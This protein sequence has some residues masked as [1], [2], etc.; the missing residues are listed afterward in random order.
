MMQRALLRSPVH[1]ATVLSIGVAVG[2]AST[3][4]GVGY[5]VFVKP[6][7]FEAPERVVVIAGISRPPFGTRL[8]W[9]STADTFDVLAEYQAVPALVEAPIGVTEVVAAHVSPGFFRAAGLRLTRGRGPDP[10]LDPKSPG[11]AVISSTLAS[12]LGLDLGS[13]VRVSEQTYAII[14][15][16]PSSGGFPE[17]CD[18]WTTDSSIVADARAPRRVIGR[19]KRGSTIEGATAQLQALQ[20]S[21]ESIAS[22][23]D[24]QAGTG[25]VVVVRTLRD[26]LLGD[27]R[28][29]ALLLVGGAVLVLLAGCLNAILLLISG[30]RSRAHDVA[31]RLALGATA[32]HLFRDRLLEVVSIAVGAGVIGFIVHQ[33]VSAAQKALFPSAFASPGSWFIP[34]LAFG[35]AFLLSGLVTVCAHWRLSRENTVTLL[36]RSFDAA[37]HKGSRSRMLPWLGVAQTTLAVWLSVLAT[38]IGSSVLALSRADAGFAGD[39][40]VLLVDVR[41]QPRREAADE[42]PAALNVLTAAS[43]T[44]EVAFI[45]KPPFGGLPRSGFWFGL[46]QDETQGDVFLTSTVSPGY[47]SLMNIRIIRG[48]S[49]GPEDRDGA[50][51]V[52]MLNDV[53]ARQLWPGVDPIGQQLKVERHLRT[54]VGVVS[55]VKYER[56]DEEGGLQA[57]VPLAQAIRLGDS[58]AFVLRAG[59]QKGDVLAR[60]RAIMNREHVQVHVRGVRSVGTL[61]QMS[62]RAER[63][64]AGAA[65]AAAGTAVLLSL[66][67]ILGMTGDFLRRSRHELGLRSALGASPWNLAMVVLRKFGTPVAIGWCFGLTLSYWS[68]RVMPAVWSVARHAEETTVVVVAAGVLVVSLATAAGAGRRMYH[69]SPRTLMVDDSAGST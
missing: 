40:T 52:M 22:Q 37:F 57:Y 51:P 24:A 36:H 32:R 68:T 50:P 53:A 58:A 25:S 34:A 31:I 29:R 23:T 61:K 56:V 15:I 16:V 65:L 42:F 69:A 43:P 3:A 59:D 41:L 28:S 21:H 60:V 67:G 38:S 11:P 26:T 4:L 66:L 18:F 8:E 64:L 17:S 10:A 54:V 5:S 14:G 63:V 62:L 30:A 49:F 7:P 2:I 45:D 13:S 12:R 39:G 6:L 35:L 19:L 27:V 9:F 33:A 48:R 46:P 55:T 1:A 44:A 20:R 47:F